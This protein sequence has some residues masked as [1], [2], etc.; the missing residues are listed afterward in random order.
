LLRGGAAEAAVVETLDPERLLPHVGDDL[1][2]RLELADTSVDLLVRRFQAGELVAGLVRE[3]QPVELGVQVRQPPP[4]VLLVVDELVYG[5]ELV[6]V[7]WIHNNASHWSCGTCG[8]V[9][10]GSSEVRDVAASAFRAEVRRV[11]ASARGCKFK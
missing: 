2:S 3:R 11:A 1:L 10:F 6:Q 7:H 8:H 9:G 5:A 4:D